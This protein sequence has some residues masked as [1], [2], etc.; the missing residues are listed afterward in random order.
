MQLAKLYPR[1]H[2]RFLSLP[3]LGQVIQGYAT[4]LFAKGYP[5]HRVRVHVRKTRVID[6][7]LG[8]R[9]VHRLEELTRA[10]LCACRPLCSQD[11][12]EL[13][14]AVQSL[15]RYL[16][17]HALLPPV[18]LPTRSAALVDTYGAFLSANRGLANNTVTQHSR[19]AAEL[20]EHVGYEDNP[21]SLSC[22]TPDDLDDFVCAIAGRFT[23]ESLQ[24]EVAH[25]RAFTRFL[26]GDG[27]TTPGLDTQLDTP[28]V[29]RLER[30]PRGLPWKTVQDFLDSIDRKTPLGQRDYV[31]FFLIATYGLRASEVVDLTLDDIDWRRDTLRIRQRKT[32]SP[33]L[34]PLV[35]SAGNLLVDYLRRWRPSSS[36]RHLF[37]RAR[38]PEGTLKPTAVTE[39]F[40]AW[41]KR[42]GLDIVFNG[43]HCLRHSYAVHLLRQGTPLKTIGDILGHRSAES[44]CVYLRLAIDDLREV[45]LSLPTSLDQPR[46]TET[47]P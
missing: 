17:E 36:F 7:A 8:R 24:H 12:A 10:D 33:L 18:D 43:A 11:D 29:Y 47:Q 5:R 14:C 2:Q 3:I 37:L 22:V 27:L 28:R 13:T 9:G 46:A 20:L 35:N 26:A 31:I 16:D 42:S 41:S 34:L 39:A 19:T 44:T 40:Q 30:L 32:L 45:A 4:W 25:I 23:R 15:F 21:S 38:A 6:D 1:F